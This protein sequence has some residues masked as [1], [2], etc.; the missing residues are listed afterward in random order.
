MQG[1]RVKE[2][3][4]VELL[5]QIT[6]GWQPVTGIA[7]EQLRLARQG[8]AATLVAGKAAP[9]VHA[10]SL[11]ANAAEP[12]LVAELRGLVTE[13]HM[14]GTRQ[15]VGVVRSALAADI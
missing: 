1:R 13:V 10:A 5:S 4:V 2:Q 12:V 9:E 14:A 11:P 8:L 6:S 15:N 3:A 7:S